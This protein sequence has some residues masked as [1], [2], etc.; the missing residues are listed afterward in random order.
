MPNE[1]KPFTIPQRIQT[2]RYRDIET[3]VI[4]VVFLIGVISALIMFVDTIGLI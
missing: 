1:K 2:Q 4:V 3:G